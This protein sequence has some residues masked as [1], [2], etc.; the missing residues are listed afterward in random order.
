MGCAKSRDAGS[1]SVPPPSTLD[2]QGLDGPTRFE[3]ILPFAR[4]KIDVLETKLKAASGDKKSLTFDELKEAFT[5]DKNWE[6]LS[7]NS[8]LL[9]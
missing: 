4:V 6:A 1:E 3:T 7:D 5:G 2:L 8:S 9:H